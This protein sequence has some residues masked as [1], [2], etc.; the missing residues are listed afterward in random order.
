MGFI[1]EF[2]TRNRAFSERYGAGL[3]VLHTGTGT[4]QVFGLG[5]VGHGGIGVGE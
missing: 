5:G 1:G 3:S 4:L 2:K